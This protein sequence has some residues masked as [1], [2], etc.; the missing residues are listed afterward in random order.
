LW[1]KAEMRNRRLAIVDGGAKKLINCCASLKN[2]RH[3]LT[4][5]M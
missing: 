3:H 4:A 1:L 2:S 5:L